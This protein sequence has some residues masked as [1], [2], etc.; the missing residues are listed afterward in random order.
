MSSASMLSIDTSGAVVITAGTVSSDERL[1]K[2]ITD[3]S[4]PLSTINALRGRTFKWID[5]TLPIGTQYGLIAQEVESIL[6]DL[7][8]E[9]SAKQLNA[10]GTLFKGDNLE[11]TMTVDEAVAARNLT[12]T[13]SVNMNGIIPIL[14]EAVKELSAKVTALE[15][16]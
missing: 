5:E 1:K 6:P 9:S 10:D 4:S 14:I 8:K 12:N 3:L 7:I 15:N 16:A 11:D 13:K 2:D